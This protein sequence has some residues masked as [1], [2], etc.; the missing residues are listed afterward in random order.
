MN[1]AAPDDYIVKL[2]ESEKINKYQDLVREEKNM[3]DESDGDIN[4]NW[5]ARYSHQE[6]YAGSGEFGNKRT[7]GLVWFGFM[8]YQP[9]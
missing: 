7:S 4:C 3:E 9:L 8:A 1:F 6:T 2:K 5:C